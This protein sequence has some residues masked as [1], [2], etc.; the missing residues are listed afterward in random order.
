MLSAGYRGFAPVA[1]TMRSVVYKCALRGVAQANGNTFTLPK[2]TFGGTIVAQGKGQYHPGPSW[3]L[4]KE[5]WF[6]MPTLEEKK[7]KLENQ[8]AQK[9]TQLNKLK[10]KQRR[11]ERA[12]RT[13]RLI[14]HGA[15]AEKYLHAPDMA[16][17]DF[18]K[19]LA[20]IVTISQVMNLLPDVGQDEQG[21]PAENEK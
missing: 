14:E 3:D 21:A 5:R 12:A 16:T 18:E 17:E 1:H 8:I 10:N 4:A 15:L 2:S 9:K 11:Q 13:R 6:P 20:R 19:L 7:Q